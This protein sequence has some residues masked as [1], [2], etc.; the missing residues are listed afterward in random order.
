MRIFDKET[1]ET[2]EAQR[3]ASEIPRVK[4]YSTLKII[5]AL[6]DQWPAYRQMI[7]DAGFSDQFFAANYLASDDPVFASF[8]AGVPEEL[9]ERLDECEWDAE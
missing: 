2:I 8:L 5:R 7:E 3:R 9:K 6:G 1:F 4:K